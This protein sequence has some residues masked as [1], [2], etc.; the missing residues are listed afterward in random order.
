MCIR[1]SLKATR[2]PGDAVISTGTGV[3]LYIAMAGTL[4]LLA[5]LPAVALISAVRRSR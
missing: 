2:I 4:F 5:A 1:D 3:A